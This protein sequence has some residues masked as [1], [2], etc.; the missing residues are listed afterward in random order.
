MDLQEEVV[1]GSATYPPVPRRAGV[2]SRLPVILV[3]LAFVGF[4]IRLF[5]LISRY[6]VDIFF[7]DQWDFNDATLFEHHSWWEIFTWQPGPQRQGLGGI[8]AK[9]VEPSFRWN[10]RIESFLVGGIIVGSAVLVLWLRHRLFGP[11]SFLDVIIPIIYFTPRQYENIFVTANIARDSL[12]ALLFVIYCLIWTMDPG[13]KRYSSVV[14]LNF[15]L[16][17]TGFGF[18]AGVLTPILLVLDYRAQREPPPRSRMQLAGAFALSIVSLA[19]FFVDYHSRP[20]LN[21]FSWKPLSPRL[22]VRF[23]AVMFS[24]FFAVPGTGRLARCV[25]TSLLVTLVSAV[26][27]S[28]WKMT[29]RAVVGRA[30]DDWRRPLVITTLIGFSLMFAANAAYGRLCGGLPIAQSSRY[31]IFL[32]PAVL[33]L[34]FFAISIPRGQL[35]VLLAT[36]LL[37]ALIPAAVHID[38]SWFE[39]P[40][41]KAR[42]RSCYLATEEIKNCDTV[43]GFPIYPVPEATHLKEKLEFLKKTRQNL[44]ATN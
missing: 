27:V 5:Y 19:S 41:H 31:V 11:F 43:A 13:W 32:E 42:W 12:P 6:A 3:G 34:Y 39:L 10:S 4:A 18:F 21:C 22:Y 28:I 29:K 35:R 15:L 2:I 24:N 14:V 25:G 17:Y 9:L 7:W 20:G 36:A 8:V 16:I 44:Y 37:V 1:G 33:G 23:M 38:E 40:K 30:P 26:L